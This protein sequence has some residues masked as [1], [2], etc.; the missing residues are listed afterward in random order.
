LNLDAPLRTTPSLPSD[1]RAGRRLEYFTLVWNLGEAAVAIASGLV[2]SSIALLGFGFDSVIECLSGATLL[3]RLHAHHG[4]A[5]EK[6]ALRL[7][8]GSFLL[9]AAYVAFDA[10]KALLIREAPHES[11]VGIA[12]AVASLVV[13]PLLARAKRRVA[14]RLHSRALHSD[15]R[16][17]DLCAYLSAILLGG[18][19]LNALFGWWWADPIAALIMVPII[20]REGLLGLR[21]DT[22]EDCQPAHLRSVA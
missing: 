11:V 18:L 6:R 5:R 17:T 14:V 16:Q 4:E 12:L 10:G 1:L 9:L 21:G 3:W 8:G 13:M 2:A 7:V 22:C 19:V 20:A 15:S